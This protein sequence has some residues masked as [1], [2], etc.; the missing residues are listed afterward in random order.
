M[1]FFVIVFFF[2]GST[3]YRPLMNVKKLAIFSREFAEIFVHKIGLSTDYPR[4]VRSFR[5]LFCVK[6]DFSAVKSV[7]S[8]DF[9][10][11]ILQ[12]GMPSRRIIRG[13]FD[14][15]RIILRKGMPFRRI[16]HGKSKRSAN[17]PAES[18][19]L[20]RGRSKPHFLKSITTSKTN[21]RQKFNHG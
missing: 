7:E 19:L 9:S 3:P 17:Y 20:Y 13:S 1:R 5:E 16:I 12:T 11:T 6:G 10:W 21:F 8:F 2:H 14:F 18:S 15:P 4:K